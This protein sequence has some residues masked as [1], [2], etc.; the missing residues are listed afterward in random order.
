MNKLLAK[1]LIVFLLFGMVQQPAHAL[2]APLAGTPSLPILF[3]V[4][5]SSDLQSSANELTS[6]NN[7]LTSNG[8]SG[9]TIAGDFL[10]ITLNPGWNVGHELEAAWSKGFMPFFYLNPSATWEGPYYS[11]NCDT[12][13]D[14][15]S[16][17][18]DSLLTTFAGYYKGWVDMGGG[19][20]AFIAPMSEANSNWT[21]YE[22]DGATFINAFRHIRQVFETQ[23]VTSSMVRWVFAPNGWN[24]PARPWQAFENYYPGDAY[25]DILAFSAFNYGGCPVD[26]P[27]RIWDTFETAIEP[28]LVRMRALAPSKPIFI[29]QTGTVNVPDSSDPNETKSNWIYDTFNKLANYPAVRAI[30][31]FNKVKAE[32]SLVNCPAG[33]DY[34]IHYGGSSGEVGFLNIMK[35][36]RFGKWSLGDSK[37][38]TFAYIDP[39]YTFADVQPAHPFSGVSNVWYYDYVLSL[40]NAGITGG[41]TTSP[42]NYCPESPVTRAQMA[43][44]L[45][46]GI[47]GS[48]YSPPTVG[49]STGFT[50]VPVSYWA[51]PW[52]KQ[53]A[54]EGITG[55]CGTGIYC[56]D[57]TVT[58]A[59][60]AIFLLKAKHTSAYT[61]PPATGVFTDV[62]VG[63]WARAWIEQ[64]A[65][66][67]ITGGC[68]VGVY[69]PDSSV[70]RAQM[71]VFLVKTFNLP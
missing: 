9:V 60:M 41:C 33:A 8:A 4:F 7:W 36:S 62:P 23:G 68:G 15:A 37:W 3:G 54:A 18:C 65:L 63:Y 20:R 46:K 71:A 10:S 1:L 55:G 52:I 38:N 28:Y 31:Y 12:A 61:P 14:I 22:S 11:A 48:S 53:L 2:S 45:L 40:Y 67:G 56:P 29:A 34:R 66:E 58:R 17:L 51:A 42:L 69:C 59:Q 43:I 49:T 32:A 25:A 16:G 70:T 27:W 6:M 44:F 26:A 64:L 5:T 19:R 35:D 39:P 24:D 30:I 13:A 47:H 57:A 50:D 21:P